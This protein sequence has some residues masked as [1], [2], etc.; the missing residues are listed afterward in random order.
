MG[1]KPSPYNA[2]RTFMWGEV[3]IRGNPSDETSPFQW[4]N[5]EL[6]LPGDPF[7]DPTRPWV[8]K[9]R[10]DG[11]LALDV[12]SYV[13]D[14]RSSGASEEL[15]KQATKRIASVVNYFG[16]QDAPRKR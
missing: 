11:L 15:C 10:N 9:R 4:N 1:F 16:M 13:D 8:S 7:Y 2:C 14:L 6:N 5:V 12:L 3:L